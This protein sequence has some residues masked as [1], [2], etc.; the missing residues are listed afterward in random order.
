M[1]LTEQWISCTL[2]LTLAALLTGARGSAQLYDFGTLTSD[3]QLST[4]DELYMLVNLTDSSTYL[5]GAEKEIYV[6]NVYHYMV[7]LLAK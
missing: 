5:G 1:R 7:S 2:L 6:S 3:I 4:A